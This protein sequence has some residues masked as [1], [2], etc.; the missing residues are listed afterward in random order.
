LGRKPTG[1]ANPI[2][3][4]HYYLDVELER[5]KGDRVK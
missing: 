1:E 5:A 2:D 3:F 4:V